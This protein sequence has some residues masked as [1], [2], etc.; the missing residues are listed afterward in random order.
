MELEIRDFEFLEIPQRVYAR[1]GGC[2]MALKNARRGIWLAGSMLKWAG[3]RAEKASWWQGS[4]FQ[5]SSVQS[6]RCVDPVTPWTAA[7]QASL[8]ITN[9][10]SLLKL[11]S[12]ESVIPSNYLS[13]NIRKFMVHVLLKPGLENFKHYF[14]SL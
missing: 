13:L 3:V 2:L 8:S 7:C 6:L 1:R 11:I 9:S 10:Q 5:F 12:I 4:P 14:T